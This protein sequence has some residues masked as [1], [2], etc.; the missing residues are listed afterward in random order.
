MDE[1]QFYKDLC[2]Q[3]YKEINKL[4]V[5]ARQKLISALL[6]KGL[7]VQSINKEYT[8]DVDIDYYRESHILKL[9]PHS[10][11][12]ANL[13]IYYHL[14]STNETIK[15]LTK[16]KAVEIV[17]S[18][19]QSKGR[20]RRGKQWISPLGNNIYFSIRFL[21]PPKQNRTLYPIYIAIVIVEFL[22]EY[23]VENVQIK[24]PN[25]IYIQGKK[26]IGL[27]LELFTDY[28]ARQSLILGI[29]INLHQS[30]ANKNL[31]DQNVTDLCEHSQCK[32]ITDKNNLLALLLPKLIK[33]TKAFEQL[34][35]EV[36]ISRFEQFNYL[37]DKMIEIKEKDRTQIGTFVKLNADGSLVAEIN[38]TQHTF[39]SADVSVRSNR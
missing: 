12:E 6:G 26:L 9:F 30:I 34:D 33:S 21:N 3:Q 17:L 14:E 1:Y 11:I 23:N 25:D 39:Y 10:Q 7:C 2:D 24:W 20:G 13:N 28:E 15:T 37:K 16:T 27:M 29:G 18:E 38:N 5:K 19:Y 32:Q 36:I 31:I 4:E 35:S 8:V 22:K